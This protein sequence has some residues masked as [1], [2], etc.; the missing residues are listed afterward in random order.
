MNPKLLIATH[1]ELILWD[2][3]PHILMKNK[4]HNKVH[5]YYGITWDNENIYVSERI[6]LQCHIHVFNKKLKRIGELPIGVDLASVHQIFWYNGILYITNTQRNQILLWGGWN[7]N[8]RTVEWKKPNEPHQHLNSIWCDGKNFF[9]VEHRKKLIPKRIRVLDLDFTPV[10]CIE[11]DGDFIRDHPEGIHNVYIENE[12]LYTCGPQALIQHNLIS[13]RSKPIVPHPLM[14][15]HHYARGLAR[16]AGKFFV[17]LS[18]ASERSER[19]RGNSTILV[20]DDNFNVLETIVLKGTG[21]IH[22]IRAIDGIDL[23]HNG[24]ICPYSY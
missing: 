10:D 15:N 23:A 6:W 9:V 24:I 4:K 5:D 19:N 12:K 2:G 11:L 14:N 8:I 22:E 17:G 16:T 1:N 3:S 20:T 13:G 18:E 21:G 7:W